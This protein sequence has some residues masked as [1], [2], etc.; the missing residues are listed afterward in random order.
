MSNADKVIPGVEIEIFGESNAD[1]VIPGVEIEIFGETRTLVTT[2]RTL[3]LF[4]RKTGKNGMR[5]FD[6]NVEDLCVLV[7]AALGG[8][9]SGRT[10]DEVVDE[11]SGRHA[12]EIRRLIAGL[13]EQAELS[14]QQKN[15]DAA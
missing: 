8:D 3:I 6:W 15:D 5:R 12:G 2:F 13:F 14:D 9:K 11:L 4:E 10:V 1:K 7:W